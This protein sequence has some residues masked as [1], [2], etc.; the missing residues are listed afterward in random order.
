MSNQKLS[1]REVVKENNL[2]VAECREFFWE[3][4]EVTGEY[5]LSDC[6]E[7]SSDYLSDNQYDQFIRTRNLL[8]LKCDRKG[9][10]FHRI[11]QDVSQ[12]FLA[13]QEQELKIEEVID[14]LKEIY[15]TISDKDFLNVIEQAILLIR[16]HTIED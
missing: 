6:V 10:D 11:S 13:S 16:T 14:G 7:E 9:I 12:E 5:F 4:I 3:L 8:N 15:K 2:L 1:L